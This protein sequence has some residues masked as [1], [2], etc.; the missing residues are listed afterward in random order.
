MRIL[1]VGTAK[2][3]ADLIKAFKENDIEVYACC[4]RDLK[5][6]EDFAKAN[7]V[8]M[9]YDDYEKALGDKNIDAV[10]IATPNS[11]HYEYASKAIL[12]HKHVILEKPFT[13]SAKECLDLIKLAI[14]NDVI[15]FEAILP[16]HLP[17]YKKLKE[18]I[19]SLGKI[20]NAEL[21]FSKYSSKYDDFKK[22]GS[23]NVFNPEFYGGALNDLGVYT[24]YYAIDIFGLANKYAYFCNMERDI[25]VSGTYILT[26]D[27][28]YI[29]GTSLKDSNAHNFISISGENGRIYYEGAPSLIDNFKIEMR[30]G[31]NIEYHYPLK[32]A[33]YYEVSIFKKMILDN[34]RQMM[35]KY[36]YKT[37]QVMTALDKLHASQQ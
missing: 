17:A 10:Y 8:N 2:I 14:D 19:K 13:T 25:D 36:L 22:G 6:T 21:N 11:L 24:L 27:N 1:T 29:T 26:Y 37:Y 33:Y 20:T 31:E 35:K 4:G 32:D 15:L 16:I 12:R 7:G 5:K 28:F 9:A 34:D 30:N 18:A 3:T 23:P